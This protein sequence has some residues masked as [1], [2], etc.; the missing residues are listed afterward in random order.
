MVIRLVLQC[1]TQDDPSIP[2]CSNGVVSYE[3]TTKLH[4]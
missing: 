4:C 2:F 3:L 1:I